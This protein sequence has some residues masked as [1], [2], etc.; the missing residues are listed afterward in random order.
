MVGNI[1][2]SDAGT[3]GIAMSDFANPAPGRAAK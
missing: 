2:M 3:D 1:Y